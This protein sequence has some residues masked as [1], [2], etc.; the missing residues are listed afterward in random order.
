MN[1]IKCKCNILRKVNAKMVPSTDGAKAFPIKTGLILAI[2]VLGRLASMY[3]LRALGEALEIGL[4]GTLSTAW[5][6]VI[7]FLPVICYILV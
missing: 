2:H 1:C 4:N 7:I 6:G 3:A 5:S